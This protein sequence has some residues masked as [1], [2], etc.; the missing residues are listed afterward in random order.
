[1]KRNESPHKEVYS[2]FKSLFELLIGLILIIT[3]IVMIVIVNI[4][5]EKVDDTLIELHDPIEPQEVRDF[6][7]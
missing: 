7:K 3:F 5:K 1:M 4:E 6:R 2:Y